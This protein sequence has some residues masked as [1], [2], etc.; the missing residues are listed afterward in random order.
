MVYWRVLRVLRHKLVIVLGRV[1]LVEFIQLD[2]LYQ[3]VGILRIRGIACCLQTARPSLIVGDVEFEEMAVALTALPAM[4]Q[5]WQS[6]SAMQGS[7]SSYSPQVTAVGATDVNDMATTTET[8]QSQPKGPNRAKK[9]DTGGESG[10]SSEPPVGD[11]VLP[12][13]VMAFV[14]CGVIALRRKRAMKS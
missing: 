14:F 8:N 1:I 9:F 13:M 12:L 4:A 6:T 11:A 2:N 10:Q 3:F 5:D 7:G